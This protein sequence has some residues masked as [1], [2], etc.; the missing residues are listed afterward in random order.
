MLFKDIRRVM[1]FQKGVRYNKQ[2]SRFITKQLF[3]FN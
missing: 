3:L 2:K 1:N